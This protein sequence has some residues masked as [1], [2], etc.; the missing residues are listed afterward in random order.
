MGSISR[1]ERVRL[2]LDPHSLQAALVAEQLVV[3]MPFGQ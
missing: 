2:V 1:S 3:Q